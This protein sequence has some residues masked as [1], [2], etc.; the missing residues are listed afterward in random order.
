[1]CHYNIEK[2][3]EQVPAN[4]IKQFQE[5][6]G[7]EIRNITAVPCH[8]QDISGNGKEQGDQDNGDQTLD[9][10]IKQVI[11]ARGMQ[12]FEPVSQL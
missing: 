10:N 8:T 4:L 11:G 3:T 6:I 2:N 12:P 9:R 1:M 5:E 7:T